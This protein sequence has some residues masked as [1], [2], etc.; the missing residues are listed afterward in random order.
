M[1]IVGGGGLHSPPF[2]SYVFNISFLPNF[3]KNITYSLIIRFCN[4]I[5]EVKNLKMGRVVHPPLQIG[6]GARG[7]LWVMYAP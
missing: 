2:T 1:H 5:C 4:E 6:G 7:V 3:V